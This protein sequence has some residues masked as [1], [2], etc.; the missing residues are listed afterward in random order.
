VRR[1]LRRRRIELH[2]DENGLIVHAPWRASERRIVGAVQAHADWVLKKLQ[3]WRAA[4]PRVRHWVQGAAI[5]F[6]G[7]ELRLE[8]AVEATAAVQLLDDDRLR[9]RVAEVNEFTHPQEQSQRIR[10]SVV[11]WYRRH[12]QPLFNASVQRHSPL[13]EVTAPK[14]F[15]SNA[16]GRWGSCNSRSQVR[17]NW[18][19]IQARQAVI[20]YVVV[21]ELAHLREMNHSTRFWSLVESVCPDYRVARADL[22]RVGGDYMA[23]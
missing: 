6:L 9:V 5:P 2:V 19:L 12:A 20:D 3:T 7:R 22:D 16:R 23:L 14:V 10:D 8:L 18:R 17:L 15:L 1:S 11:A 13:L 21:H 4:A